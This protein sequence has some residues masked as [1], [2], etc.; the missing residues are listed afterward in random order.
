MVEIESSWRDERF[1]NSPLLSSGLGKKGT[2]AFYQVV[3][4]S[5]N[6]IQSL[7]SFGRSS[8]RGGAPDEHGQLD[9]EQK[10]NIASTRARHQENLKGS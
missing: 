5:T 4:I 9:E 10:Q 8:E 2:F 1:V 6:S 3:S 7:S